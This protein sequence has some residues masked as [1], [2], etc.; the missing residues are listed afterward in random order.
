MQ[1]LLAVMAAFIRYNGTYVCII[2]IC[3]RRGMS[4]PYSTYIWQ[5]ARHPADKGQ[6]IEHVQVSTEHCVRYLANLI[7]QDTRSVM[8]VVRY[9]LTLACH[10]DEKTVA[11]VERQIARQNVSHHGSN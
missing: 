2:A 9:R 7:H 6:W 5:P 4:H 10:P 11:L 3:R 1:M 8:K